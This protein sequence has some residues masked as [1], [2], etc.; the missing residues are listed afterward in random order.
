MQ[1][2]GLVML[3]ILAL[4]LMAMI[5]WSCAYVYYGRLWFRSRLKGCPVSL[6]RMM[7]MTFRGISAFDVVTAYMNAHL[8][9]IEVE[10]DDL[11]AHAGEK[12]RSRDVV[13]AM[14]A[15]RQTGSSVSFSEART[16]DLQGKD[17]V[18]EANGSG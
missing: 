18:Q 17:V 7:R 13:K 2:S 4:G 9:Q 15:A 1:P 14:I 5:V 16:L 11:E 3:L 6:G 10:L 8:A 12:G